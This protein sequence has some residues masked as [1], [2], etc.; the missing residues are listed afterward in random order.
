MSSSRKAT[1]IVTQGLPVRGNKRSQ[2]IDHT[3]L[4]PRPQMEQI[5]DYLQNG[6]EHVRFPD[7]EAKFIRNHPY[8][9]QLDF[10][11]MQED[12]QRAWE[13]QVRNKEAE[14]L[15]EDLHRTHALVRAAER[16]DI[17]VGEH[18]PQWIADW[19][20]MAENATDVW[21]AEAHRM[22]TQD[23]SKKDLMAQTMG[24]AIRESTVNPS[25]SL[26][27]YIA[28]PNDPEPGPDGKFHW[29]EVGDQWDARRH[30]LRGR[31]P[32]G[33][34]PI[35]LPDNREAGEFNPIHHMWSRGP[36]GE[37]FK[38]AISEGARFGLQG[39]KNLGAKALKKL[40]GPTPEERAIME[41]EAAQERRWDEEQAMYRE[42]ERQ[43]KEQESAMAAMEKEASKAQYE[44]IHGPRLQLE[45]RAAEQASSSSAA[46]ADDKHAP[47][48]RQVSEKI[49]TRGDQITGDWRKPLIDKIGGV[50]PNRDNRLV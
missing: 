18:D 3:G 37:L 4:R 28:P 10:F 27:D 32:T 50:T 45:K 30:R 15:A 16:H 35:A 44:A 38:I 36:D 8:M 29:A 7:R 26:W 46:A 5:V 11:D 20:A 47:F 43:Q 25:T 41:E 2:G 31:Y 12:Q 21:E 1:E 6:Q 19:D 13:D 40:R 42:W 48:H 49:R 14:R 17:A 9:T 39:A 33:P 34:T 23:D 22:D 24:Y